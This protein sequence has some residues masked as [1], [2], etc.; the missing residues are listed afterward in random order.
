MLKFL[1][2]LWWFL[3]SG[4]ICPWPPCTP[5]L[6]FNKVIESNNWTSDMSPFYPVKPCPYRNPRRAPLPMQ[7]AIFNNP[8]QV[9]VIKCKT[10]VPS[11]IQSAWPISPIVKCSHEILFFGK[12]LKTFGCV[13]ITC[14]NSDHY[15]PWLRVGLVDQSKQVWRI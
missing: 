7:F 13:D 5:F 9:N 6:I 2:I 11:M 4:I 8:L 1:V 10:C 14:E 3:P 12:I 15:R